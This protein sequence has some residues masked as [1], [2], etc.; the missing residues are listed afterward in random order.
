MRQKNI[1][2]SE[3]REGTRLRFTHTSTNKDPHTDGRCRA[4]L[5]AAIGRMM[6]E[7]HTRLENR[8]GPHRPWPGTRRGGRPRGAVRDERRRRPLHPLTSPYIPLH[9]STGLL[10]K[11]PRG[12]T[13][14]FKGFFPR[15][16]TRSFD[17]FATN[18]CTTGARVS[19]P[20]S[21]RSKTQEVIKA[22]LLRPPL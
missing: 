12:S 1:Q 15:R 11:I 8:A 7:A 10:E 4:R 6:N 14:T 20:R 5:C 9:P 2:W 18:E 13:S 16:F 19:F 22:G 3:Q 21:I 17:C